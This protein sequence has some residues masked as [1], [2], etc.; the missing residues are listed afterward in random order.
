[1]TKRPALPV[2]NLSGDTQ[3]LFDVLNEGSDLACVLVAASFLDEC[4]RSLL[5][6]HFVDSDIAEDLLNPTNGALGTFASRSDTAYCLGLI[7]LRQRDDLRIIARIRNLFA[8]SHL[9][10][11]FGS[12][13]AIDFANNLIYCDALQSTGLFINIPDPTMEQI[14]SNAR[15]RFVLT[16]TLLGQGLLLAGYT[17]PHTPEKGVTSADA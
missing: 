4:L 15:G 9:E 1:M 8:H 5:R 3:K 10:I 13:A 7:N 17:T 16:V 12:Q 11:T 14:R 6:R 2:E